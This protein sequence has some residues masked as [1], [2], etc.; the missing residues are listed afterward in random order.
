MNK[1]CAAAAASV[2]VCLLL[3]SCGGGGTGGDAGAGG[4]AAAGG[5]QI[6]VENCGGFTAADAASILGIEVSMVE[7]SSPPLGDN[8]KWCVFSSSA[9]SMASLNF[10][11]SRADS[12]QDAITE[13]AQFRNN[14]GVANA[15]LGDA[16][17]AAHDVAD[18]GDEAVWTPVPGL[19]LVR[20][21]RFSLSINP[22]ST[23]EQQVRIARIILERQ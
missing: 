3:A 22:P 20:A 4:G 11:I 23:E 16:G 15:V 12:E 18:L 9:D 14:A 21:G 2:A 7:E 5:Y 1:R 8:Q 6:D 13:F 17:D 10:T 19:L